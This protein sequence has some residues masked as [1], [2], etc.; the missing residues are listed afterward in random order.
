MYLSN[1]VE[2]LVHTSND[3]RRAIGLFV[4]RHHSTISQYTIG[5][6]ARETHT[7]KA[8]VTRF[9]KTLGYDGW[10]DFLRDFVK[11]D[12]FDQ[13]HQADVDVNFPFSS[14]DDDE[15]ILERIGDLMAETVAATYH[16]LDRGMLRFAV[17]QIEASSHVWLFGLPPH[18]YTCSHFARMLLSIGKH[19]TVAEFGAY[20]VAA[21]AL[22]PE[23]CAILVSYSGNN[24]QSNPMK[25]VPTLIKNK[26]KLV[27]I[28]GEGNNYLRRNIPCTLTLASRERLY[29]KIANYATEESLS[30]ILN[31]IFSCLFARNYSRNLSFRV[32]WA[33]RLE[34]E[35]TDAIEGL[36]ES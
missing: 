7:S 31:V 1:R 29:N 27:A 11:E 4:L 9:A 5:D 25:Q 22:G 21:N 15:Q 33:E 17:N 14:A 35:R 3:V 19:A 18:N 13:Q 6:I 24:P 20:G 12:M 26:V 23:D 16:Q 10:R 34:G 2:E 28:T 30:Y 32:D 36:I 8:S